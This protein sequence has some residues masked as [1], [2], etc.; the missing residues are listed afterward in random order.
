MLNP[1]DRVKL[2]Q[3]EEF[4]KNDNTSIFVPSGHTG[5]VVETFSFAASAQSRWMMVKVLLDPIDDV[6]Y[7]LSITPIALDKVIT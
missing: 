7:T 5:V 1:D 6:H 4:I 2:R 3:A